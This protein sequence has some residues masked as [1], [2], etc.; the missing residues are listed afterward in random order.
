MIE[1]NVVYVP[2]DA[3]HEKATGTC[4]YRGR[5]VY[6]HPKGYYVTLEFQGKGG[7]FRECFEP[8]KLMPV[9]S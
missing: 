6:R 2:Y 5:E 8:S 3:F 4:I 9:P 7:C 1:W